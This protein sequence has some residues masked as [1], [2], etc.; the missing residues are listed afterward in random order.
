MLIKDP[1]SHQGQDRSY[2][3]SLSIIACMTREGELTLFSRA[4][5]S[6]LMVEI[7]CRHC[8]HAA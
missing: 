7:E 2:L 6:L 1:S 8:P 4:A 3:T 5:R